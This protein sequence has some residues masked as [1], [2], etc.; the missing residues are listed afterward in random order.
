MRRELLLPLVGGES[1]G[2]IVSLGVFAAAVQDLRYQITHPVSLSA[3]AGGSVTLPCSFT[4]PREIEPLRDVWGFTHPDYGGRIVLVGD[5][6]GNRTASIRIDRL[7]ESDASEYVCHVRVQKNDGTWEQWRRHVGTHLT[8]PGIP[9]GGERERELLPGTD[10]PHPGARRE[11]QDFGLTPLANHKSHKQ[12]PQTLQFP[13]IPPVPLVMGTNGYENQYPN[14]RKKVL[15]IPKD[16][17][18]DPGQYTS[19]ILPTNHAVADPLE[20]KIKRF[21]HKRKKHR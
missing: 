9:Q 13:S 12:F 20:S 19:Q 8:G 7:R 6:Q 21:I 3:P 1:P 11:S 14:K 10:P 4:Y 18:P 5:P 17:A 16:Q 2:P 15:P